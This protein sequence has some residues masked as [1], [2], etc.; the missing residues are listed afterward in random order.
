MASGIVNSIAN[1]LD[2]TT[3]LS[4]PF[5]AAAAAQGKMSG[6]T[7]EFLNRFCLDSS[8]NVRT[9]TLTCNYDDPS[10]VLTANDGSGLKQSRKALTVPI[11]TLLNVPALQLNVVTVDLAIS[12][13]QQTKQDTTSSMAIDASAGLDF[14]KMAGSG[15]VFGKILSGVAASAKVS[16]TSTDTTSASAQTK[17]KYLVHMEAVNNPPVGLQTILNF[18]TSTTNPIAPNRAKENTGYQIPTIDQMLK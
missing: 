2:F 9:T 11:V 16:N 18:L 8:G 14:S 15:G 6:H 13:D 3:M 10:G 17:V 12:I 5:E 1:S 7:I 4:Q